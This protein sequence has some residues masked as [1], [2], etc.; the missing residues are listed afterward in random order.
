[1]IKIE[2]GKMEKLID[3]GWLSY[4]S[5]F[6]SLVILP[7]KV[8]YLPPIMALWVVCWIIEKRGS[9]FSLWK[10]KEASVMLFYGF[11]IYFLWFV[12]ALL[13]TTDT[14][15]GV[16]LVFR[17]LSLIAFPLVLMSPGEMIR[18]KITF[19]LKSFSL[20]TLIYIIYSIAYAVVKS[21]YIIDGRLTFN[22]H[23]P[24]MDYENYFFGTRF[25]LEQ[26]PSYLAM[27]VTFSVFIAFESFFERRLR[28]IYRFGWFAG[29]IVLLGS[30]YFISSRAG[31]LSAIGLVPLYFTFRIVK[32]KKWK[33]VGFF[34]FVV[35]PLLFL[36][37]FT[38]ERFKY[39]VAED[40][41]TS[42]IDKVN[43]D[44]RIPIW[45]SAVKVI[46]KNL[47]LGVGPGDASKELREVYK[48]S[49]F[50]EVYYDNL[51][52]HNQYLEVLLS[53]GIIG[54]LIFM[55]I[56]GYMVYLSI[57]GRNLLLMIFLLIVLC[58]F[59]FESILNRI[60]GLTFFSLFSFILLYTGEKNEEISSEESKS[61]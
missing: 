48:N 46:K 1:M 31:M 24:E 50:S 16:V 45:T 37:F 25:A 26:H 49:G 33:T 5:C 3:E 53:M 56:L 12:A 27:Y 39:Y 13:Y 9:F 42:F 20:A 35:I 40:P 44:N 22:P 54:F 28:K 23:P 38:N 59:L 34:V 8:N 14:A 55:S 17:R 6:L 29:G 47:I 57:T 51:N 30:L 7:V 52:A 58:A 19:L 43:T 10:H 11:L 61:E 21:S 2:A 36:V 18:K 41:K 15:N 60:A 4:F 32:L